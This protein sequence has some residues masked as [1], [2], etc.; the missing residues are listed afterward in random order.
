MDLNF[1]EIPWTRY[2]FD[3]LM[4]SHRQEIVT[5][6]PYFDAPLNRS[7]RH[8]GMM[9]RIKVLLLVFVF[10]GIL[11]CATAKQALSEERTRLVGEAFEIHGRLGVYNGTPS[12]RI[13]VVGTRKVLGIR[14]TETECPIP[15]K[16]LQILREDINDRWIYGDFTIVPLTEPQEGVMQVVTLMTAKNIVVTTREG[17]FLKKVRG[18]VGIGTAEPLLAPD[19]QETVSASRWP[20]FNKNYPTSPLKK[21]LWPN[22]CVRSQK[23]ILKIFHVFPPVGF[24]LLP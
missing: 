18:M 8:R 19:R 12:C 21:A 9:T 11:Q 20:R 16:L 22:L 7:V 10:L 15:P 3:S 5:A 4:I 14:E 13:W 24:L 2:S 1:S 23:P 6:P 17:L